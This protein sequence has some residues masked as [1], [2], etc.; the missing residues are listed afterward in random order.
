MNA[1]HYMYMNCR[2]YD[3]NKSQEETTIVKMNCNTLGCAEIYQS[4]FK[5]I[6]I[7]IVENK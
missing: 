1:P 2:I 3:Y 4:K 5:I 6:G 7:A